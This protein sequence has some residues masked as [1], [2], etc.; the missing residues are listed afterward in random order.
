[1]FS[2]K[3]FGCVFFLV[4][5]LLDFDVGCTCTCSWN[6]QKTQSRLS[7]ISMI[8]PRTAFFDVLQEL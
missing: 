5:L 8:G 6:S 1:M 7:C 2:E 3:S 4:C